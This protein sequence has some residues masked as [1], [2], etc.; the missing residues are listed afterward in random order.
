MRENDGGEKVRTR[1][2]EKGDRAR[3]RKRP[4]RME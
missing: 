3:A 2:T 1:E 4:E